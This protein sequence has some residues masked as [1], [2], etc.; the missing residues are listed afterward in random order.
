MGHNKKWI[1]L[2]LLLSAQ[3]TLNL[4]F[5]PAMTQQIWTRYN[6]WQNCKKLT[7]MQLLPTSCR[8]HKEEQWEKQ[9]YK[10]IVRKKFL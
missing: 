10:K 4:K 7:V 6:T 3:L 2:A 8:I 1:S 9:N 5:I